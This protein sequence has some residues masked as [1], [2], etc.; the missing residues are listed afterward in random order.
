MYDWFAIESI[1]L[2]AEKKRRLVRYTDVDTEQQWKAMAEFVNGT[3]DEFKEAILVSYPKAVD[4][5]RG[6]VEALKKKV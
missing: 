2:D 1:V 4:V 3:Y 6:S 5:N